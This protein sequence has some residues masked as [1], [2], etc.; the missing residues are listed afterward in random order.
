LSLCLTTVGGRKV[1][2]L[3][4]HLKHP[5]EE[6]LSSGVVID[7]FTTN[8]FMCPVKAFKDWQKDKV[9]KLSTH[10]PMFRLAEGQNYTGAV[11][12]NDLRTLLKDEVDYEKFPITAHS[13]RR[14]LATFMA[15]HKYTDD[16]IMK[17][18]RWHSD[19]FKVYIDTPREVRAVL[20]EEL[21]AKVAE[22]MR[23][24]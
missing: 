13:F 5:K 18:G 6:R 15:K 10:K 11:F 14:G 24:G 4:I 2:T 19:A 1:E 8:D 16:Q 22:S 21:A 3:K 12:N 20:A 23:L 9:V 17:V 7:V